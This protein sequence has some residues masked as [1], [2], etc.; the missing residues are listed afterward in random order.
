M[1]F[2]ATE[3]GQLIGQT[4]WGAPIV[5]NTWWFCACV[6]MQVWEIGEWIRLYVRASQRGCD[7]EFFS[8]STW[9]IGFRDEQTMYLFMY[10][11]KINSRLDSS[12]LYTHYTDRNINMGWWN[13]YPWLLDAVCG[14]TLVCVYICVCVCPCVNIQ[15]T[16]AVCDIKFN[17][18][19]DRRFTFTHLREWHWISDVYG[20]WFFSSIGTLY[21][22]HA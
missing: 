17:S 6:R 3:M 5:A 8:L 12:N 13:I 20:W 7:R 19:Y 14:K 22:S 2:I 11:N 15:Y 10:F 4:I 18:K 21:E 1:S 16:V 9:S